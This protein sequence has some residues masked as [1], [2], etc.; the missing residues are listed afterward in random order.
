MR[1]ISDMDVNMF[2]NGLHDH[3][4]KMFGAHLLRDENNQIYATEYTL[5]APNAKEVRLIA[6]F[7]NYEGWKHVLT[8]IHYQGI[9][10]IE[11]P[12]NHEWAIYKFEIHTFDDKILYKSF[13]ISIICLIVISISVACPLAPPRG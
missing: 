5:Y 6:D 12:G 9:Y 4:F 1:M 11:I 2:L 7:N 8:K 13:L 3:A 10:R